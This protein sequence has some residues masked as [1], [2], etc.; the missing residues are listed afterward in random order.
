MQE[1][2]SQ[3]CKQKLVKHAKSK[4]KSKH[5]IKQNI[6]NDLSSRKLPEYIHKP[7]SVQ[8]NFAVSPEGPI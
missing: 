6:D 3:T 4:P 1:K 7:F 8:L 5:K 2:I